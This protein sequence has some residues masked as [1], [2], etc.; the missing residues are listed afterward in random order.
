MATGQHND[1]R[2]RLKSHWV[3]LV[4][5][6]VV[7]AC[8]L[9]LGDLP[10]WLA[11]IGW[12]AIFGLVVFTGGDDL[13]VT[14]YT[15][16][17]TTD[18]RARDAED[19]RFLVAVG[20]ALP[21]P[22]IVLDENA[23]VRFHNEAATAMF[24]LVKPETHLS[25]GIRTPLVLDAV[26]GVLRTKK[27]IRVDFEQR[28][29]IER[30]LEAHISPIPVPRHQ[31]AQE[32]HP[33]L[34]IL[35]R[36]L[37]D[38]DSVER[39]RADFVANASHELRTPL[40]SVLGFIETLQGAAKDDEISRMKFLELMRTQAS[41]MSRL[42]DDLLSLNRIEM[43]AHLRPDQTVD[44]HQIVAHV[45]DVMQPLAAESDVVLRVKDEPGEKTVPGDHDELVQVL[46]N[47]IENA[48]K[49]GGP[50]GKVEIATAAI[51]SRD[52]DIDQVEI[53]IRDFGPGIAPE[54]IQRLTERFYRVD[55]QASRQKGGTGLGLAIVK[56]IINRHQGRLLIESTL[57]DGAVF[58]V[59]LPKN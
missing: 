45:A 24:P 54:H 9:L 20:D 7:F 15:P 19:Q 43:N 32:S 2:V 12:W 21:D 46:Q 23:V 6:F 58:T 57:G 38:Q 37:T 48:I 3:L 31:N 18:D 28:L 11:A 41:R 44:I 10:F 53:A 26:A 52:G 14:E 13:G 36:D 35:V 17:E 33:A 16:A 22:F 55:V 39:M 56:H 5:S 50:G 51:K 49:Y 59:K 29:P 42:I 30:R 34:A 1:W 40:A 25:A 27:N 8:L 47:L 4:G